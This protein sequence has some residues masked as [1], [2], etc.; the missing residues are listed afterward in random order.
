M[1]SAWRS[2]NMALAGSCCPPRKSSV[3]PFSPRLGG[4]LCNHKPRV[5]LPMTTNP[6]ISSWD[7]LSFTSFLGPHG[8]GDHASPSISCGSAGWLGNLFPPNPL[9]SLPVW[10]NRSGWGIRVYALLVTNKDVATASFCFEL[11]LQPNYHLFSMT[12]GTGVLG[13]KG[14]VSLLSFPPS[15]LL[16]I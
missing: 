9:L 14:L 1:L 8:L 13:W 3:P 7:R 10:S 16:Q 12:C 15:P 4:L 2:T 11:S 5:I 6:Q